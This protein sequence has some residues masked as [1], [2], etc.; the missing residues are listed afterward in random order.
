MNFKHGKFDA[1]KTLEST[2]VD[3][4]TWLHVLSGT[5]GP[6]AVTLT[7]LFSGV[8]RRRKVGGHKFFS[9]KV[10]S[11]KKKKKKVTPA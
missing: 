6:L 8:A 2:E 3:R 1:L 5:L 9:Q 7:K 11:K 10:K 4:R